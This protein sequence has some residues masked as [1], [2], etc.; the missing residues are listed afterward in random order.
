[1]SDVANRARPSAAPTFGYALVVAV[2][3]LGAGS[4]AAQSDTRAI[5]AASWVNPKGEIESGGLIVVTNGRITQV[6]GAAPAGAVIDEFPDGVLSPGFID[7]YSALTAAD[8]LIESSSALQPQARAADAL[9]R[10]DHALRAAA[11]AGVSAFALAPHAGNLIGGQVA[12][13]LTGG[14]AG[15]ARP[16]SVPGPLALSLSPAVFRPERE[17]TSRSGALANLRAAFDAARSGGADDPLAML[18][19]GKRAAIFVAPSGA[20]ALSVIDL[21]TAYSFAPAV[22]HTEDARD[23][24]TELAGAKLPVIVGP[25]HY[26]S[27]RRSAAAAGILEA[28]GV[29]VAIAGGLPYQGAESLR[30]GAALAVRNGLSAKGARLAITSTPAAIYGMEKEIGALVVGA[31]AAVVVLSGDPLDLRSQ[32]L[33]VYADGRRLADR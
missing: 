7:C 3:L 27:S 21:A 23:V 30:I 29:R 19:A 26:A 17:P 16:L 32:V 6:G 9:D 2:S 20:D 14:S 1:M 4:A 22:I 33:A 28:A 5:K 13:V 15:E 12:L 8:Q 18:L 10:H 11:R 25:L 31:R 24:A